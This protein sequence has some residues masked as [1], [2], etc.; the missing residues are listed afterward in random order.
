MRRR[1]SQSRPEATAVRRRERLPSTAPVRAGSAAPVTLGRAE[2]LGHRADLAAADVVQ[3]KALVNAPH[4]D[5]GGSWTANTDNQNRVTKVVARDLKLKPNKVLPGSG[6]NSPSNA[7]SPTGWAWLKQN[8]LTHPGNPPNYVRL[9]MLNGQ[10]GGPGNDT[11]NLAPGT[12]SLNIHHENHFENEAKLWLG[13]GGEIEKYTVQVSYQGA[14]GSLQS[15]QGKAAWRNTI[16]DLWGS[17]RYVYYDNN[18]QRKTADAPFSAT[19]DA[20]L[21]AQPNWSGH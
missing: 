14:S 7:T 16:E 3:P 5:A 9:H 12:G 6:H 19:E 8:S 21:D 17:F 11:E 15:N 10:L 18:D 20:G 1:T 2:R 13:K 4:M